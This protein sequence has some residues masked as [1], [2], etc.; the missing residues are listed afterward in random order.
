M[1]PY[2][3]ATTKMKQSANQ[4]HHPH[5]KPPFGCHKKSKKV[6]KRRKERNLIPI[7]RPPSRESDDVCGKF[8]EVILAFE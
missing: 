8:G 2:P 7:H 1:H 5:S 4:Q 3:Y 6:N